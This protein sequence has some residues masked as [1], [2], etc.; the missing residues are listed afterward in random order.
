MTIASSIISVGAFPFWH[1]ED[2]GQPQDPASRLRCMAL[3]IVKAEYIMLGSLS[4]GA[5]SLLSRM[6]HPD[7][8]ERATVLE[9]CL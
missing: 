5:R 1:D 3:R 4:A 9:V 7:T 8:T 2:D 6:L